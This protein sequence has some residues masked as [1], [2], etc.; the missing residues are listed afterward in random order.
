MEIHVPLAFWSFGAKCLGSWL[1]KF[2]N[3][4]WPVKHFPERSG[5]WAFTLHLKMDFWVRSTQDLRCLTIALA[6]HS[7]HQ[8]SCLSHLLM[9]RSRHPL[10][11]TRDALWVPFPL[12]LGAPTGTSVVPALSSL[13]WSTTL[14]HFLKDAKCLSLRGALVLVTSNEGR[15]L[16]AGHC[17]ISW[18][19]NFLLLVLLWCIP[20]HTESRH[21]AA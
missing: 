21:R 14:D 5:S 9:L 19:V 4:A 16:P 1:S 12:S 8:S 6:N 3:Y 7:N 13:Q 15:Y 20:L 17:L 11:F 10:S 2:R 18:F